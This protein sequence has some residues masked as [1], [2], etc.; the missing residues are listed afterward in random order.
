[1]PSSL[2]DLEALALA[3]LI[4]LGPDA[5]GVAVHE[6]I[7][8][9]TGRAVSIGSL[10]KALRRLEEHGLITTRVGEP[11]AVRGGRAK[12][13][14]SIEPA[15]RAALT[16]EVRSLERMLGDLDLEGKAS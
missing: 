13:H 16:P 3:A 8:E 11:S 15:G 10:Y 1:M 4:R 7:A 12:K 2:S 9:R 5:Y 6:D 14:L